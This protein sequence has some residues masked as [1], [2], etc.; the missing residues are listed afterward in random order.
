MAEQ[1]IS[2]QPP[3]RSPLAVM[4]A[5]WK[6]LFLR[7]L[8]NRISRERSGWVWMLVEPVAHIG[9]LAYMITEGLRARTVAGADPIIFL[10]LGILGFFTVRN[11]MNRGI[12]AVDAGGNLYAFRQIKPVDT[13]FV[14]ALNTGF[15]EIVIFILLFAA[16]GLLGHPIT[17]GDPLRALGALFGLWLLGLGLA[18]ALSVPC[19]LVPEFGHMVRLVMTPMYFLSAAMFP[20][21][22]LPIQIREYLMWNPILHG[23][24]SLRLGFMP[25]YVV[26]PGISLLYVYGCAIPLIF[27]G[28]VLHVRYRNRL[29]T[30][31]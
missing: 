18:L 30:T 22:K 5:V 26:P 9:I 25:A 19:T 23:L 13:V 12:D 21:T 11:I 4:L 8:L 14:R 10:M 24:E 16:A 2:R 31:V 20:S 6:S 1:T 7:D 28:L 27:A 3:A 17:P 29:M 15:L